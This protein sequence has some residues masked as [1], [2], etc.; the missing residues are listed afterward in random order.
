MKKWLEEV[1]AEPFSNKNP[2]TANDLLLEP[3]AFPACS[4]TVEKNAEQITVSKAYLQ[5]L[6][7]LA[8]ANEINP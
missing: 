2:Q 7:S 8:K 6:F 5:R 1:S 4:V 3:Q